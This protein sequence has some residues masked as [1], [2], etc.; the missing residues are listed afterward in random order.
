M[1][2]SLV[3]GARRAKDDFEVSYQFALTNKFAF[4]GTGDVTAPSVS[5]VVQILVMGALALVGRR[6]GV[7]DEAR[8]MAYTIIVAVTVMQAGRSGNFLGRMNRM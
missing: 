2:G 3:A 8:A 5:K 1:V 7:D 4:T 6:F